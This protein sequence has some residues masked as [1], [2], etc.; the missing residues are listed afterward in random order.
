VKQNSLNKTNKR[1]IKKIKEIGKKLMIKEQRTLKNQRKT[2]IKFST[3]LLACN[4]VNN[5]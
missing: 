3:T 1:I 2:K 5:E 4:N